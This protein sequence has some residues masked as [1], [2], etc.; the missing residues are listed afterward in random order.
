M[1]GFLVS[2]N[3][4]SPVRGFLVSHNS[5]STN[6]TVVTLVLLRL[7]CPCVCLAF[8]NGI[9]S[10]HTGWSLTEAETLFFLSAM[11]WMLMSYPQ[12][13]GVFPGSSAD[14]DQLLQCRRSQF[15]SWVREIHC[16][17]GRL[18][19]PVFLGFPGGSVRKESTCNV[20]DLDST[21]G[22]G[23]SPG[24][25]NSYPLQYSAWRIPWMCDMKLQRVRHNWVTFTFTFPKFIYDETLNPKDNVLR[26]W[27]PWELL[28]SWGWSPHERD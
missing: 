17:R 10:A 23:R 27:D 16:R 5:D 20:A 26:R 12:I 7:L 24:E 21:P 3:S 14:K 28:G 4:K 15:D 13:H 9:P 18:P 6:V 11:V 2:H 1:G 19:T 8:D 25:G 22:L